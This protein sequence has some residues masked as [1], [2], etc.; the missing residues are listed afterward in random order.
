MVHIHTPKQNNACIQDKIN[1][2]YKQWQ[3]SLPVGEVL[4]HMKNVVLRKDNSDMSKATFSQ[5]EKSCLPLTIQLCLFHTQQ[6]PSACT[7][8]FGHF[9]L[10]VKYFHHL[11]H[12]G[13]KTKFLSLG[14]CLSCSHNTSIYQKL[15][16][17]LCYWYGFF[18][19]F[20]YYIY[21]WLPP[22]DSLP[23][24][25]WSDFVTLSTESCIATIM[26]LKTQEDLLNL[27]VEVLLLVW[28]ILSCQGHL[29]T[30]VEVILEDYLFSRYILVFKI[31][32]SRK[33]L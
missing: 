12:I 21:F 31:R 13:L 11:W 16:W 4:Y 5:Q 24:Y 23:I 32:W 26:G 8:V 28:I 19:L 6:Y 30:P 25:I 10:P 3:F 1:T 29:E 27:W 14:A 17:L 20:W 22:R 15:Q 33:Y 7:P 18:S 2:C 9:Y